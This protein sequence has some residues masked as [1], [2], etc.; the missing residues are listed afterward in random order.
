MPYRR[1]LP[2][3]SRHLLDAAETAL[4]NLIEDL[5]ADQPE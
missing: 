2:F 5:G 1:A 3:R 4:E